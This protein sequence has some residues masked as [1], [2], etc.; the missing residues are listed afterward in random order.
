MSG[1]GCDGEVSDDEPRAIPDSPQKGYIAFGQ[2]TR[3]KQARQASAS[4][5]VGVTRC[6]C[7]CG[8]NVRSACVLSAAGMSRATSLRCTRPSRARDLRT[9]EQYACDCR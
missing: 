3:S 6:R 1:S 2:R 5:V 8:F 7:A 9:L 4:S